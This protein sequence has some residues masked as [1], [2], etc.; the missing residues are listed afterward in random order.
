MKKLKAFTLVEILIVLVIIGTIMVL[1]IST[2]RKRK[3]N[4]RA[5][6]KVAYQ[7]LM[8]ASLNCA[9]DWSP[10][11]GNCSS[12]SD[13]SSTAGY[14][15][16][17]DCW[18]KYIE[19]NIEK[20]Y[21]GGIDGY[22]RKYPGFLFGDDTNGNFDGS[23]TDVTFCKMLTDRLNTLDKQNQCRSFISGIN[24]NVDLRKGVNFLDAFCAQ[25][26]DERG[27]IVCSSASNG[28]L[29]PSFITP[30]GQKFYIST[31][32]YANVPFI[33][34][35]ARERSAFRFVVVDLNGDSGP[36]TQLIR[37]GFNQ[38]GNNDNSIFPD[39]VL[40]AIK[41]DGV[42][43]PLGLPEFST[44]YA[45]AVVYYPKYLNEVDPSDPTKLKRN[46]KDNSS[47]NT[48]YD[49]KLMAWAG[50]AS[51]AD[52]TNKIFGQP[53]VQEE[54]FSFSAPLY[55]VG[56]TCVPDGCS[57]ATGASSGTS[58]YVDKLMAT[59]IWQFIVDGKDSTNDIVPRITKDGMLDE[60]HGCTYRTS[61]CRIDLTD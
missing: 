50:S 34:T 24:S 20:D 42:V 51:T 36:N 8:Q 4:Y 53:V 7:T 23:G 18:N 15:W 60:V 57:N 33:N 25:V 3:N 35:N 29:I 19:K 45:N 48:L 40:F 38:Y 41:S 5:L 47:T 58:V 43:I 6:Y 1:S 46:D 14:C 26:G 16:S 32:Q 2:V 55:S 10:S 49:A 52:I 21:L 37:G 61:K 9:Y 39:I 27:S 22:P 13:V 11:C 44:N 17:K 56:I 12:D 54:P 31:V 28:L 30:N 59:L